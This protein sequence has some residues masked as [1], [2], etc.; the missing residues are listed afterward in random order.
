MTRVGR[1][2]LV[3]LALVTLFAFALPLVWTIAPEATDPAH[4]LADPTSVHPLGTDELGRDVLSRLA[5]GGQATLVVGVAAMLTALVLGVLVGGAAGFYGGWTDGV[6]MRLT[7]AMLAIPGFFL[8]LVVVTVMGSDLF[9]LVLVIGG[10]SWMPVARVAYGETLRWKAA[11]FVLAAESLGAAPLR[12]LARHVLP[13]AV[14]VLVVSATLG[15]A[16][17]I[18]TESAISY[19]GL[20]VQPPTPSWGNMLQR[21]QQYLFTAPVLAFYPG[22]AI[23]IVVL[24]FNFAG[25]GLR[26]LLD[27]RS[28]NRA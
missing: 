18:L 10:L 25:D 14:P 11:D 5:R 22:V 12:I 17:A 16:Y 1:A 3:T 9:T 24:A 13:Q 27:P 19:L 15:V 6:L 28:R 20:G 2:A 21:A 8:V 7:D 23:V 4:R 26:D